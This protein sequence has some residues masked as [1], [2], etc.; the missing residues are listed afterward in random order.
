MICQQAYEHQEIYDNYIVQCY[1][2]QI[3]EQYLNLLH[4]IKTC[5]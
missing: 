5:I 1:P 4:I 2:Y 3:L